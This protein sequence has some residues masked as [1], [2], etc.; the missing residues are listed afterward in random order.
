MLRFNY[1]PCTSVKIPSKHHPGN[2]F[3]IMR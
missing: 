1:V 2:D 3:L